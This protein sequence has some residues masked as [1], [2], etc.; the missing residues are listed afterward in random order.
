MFDDP[1]PGPGFNTVTDAVLALAMSEV[2]TLA[3]NCESL[4][5]VVASVWRFQ[6]TTEPETKPVPFTV[7]VNPSPPG[8]TASGTS[9]WL[10]R[11]TG[12]CAIATP[13]GPVSPM[14]RQ[15][16]DANA[17]WCERRSVSGRIFLIVFM[18]A[19]LNFVS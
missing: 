4:T 2:G 18:D 12:F 14:R 8:L 16:K 5:N 13:L 1:P 3:V 17:T 15:H 6:F 9:G 10:I 11:G 19:L 7:R